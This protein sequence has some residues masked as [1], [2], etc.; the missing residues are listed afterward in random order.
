MVIVYSVILA[1]KIFYPSI[2]FV[3]ESKKI[4]YAI[5]MFTLNLV[6]ITR[7]Y[8]FIGEIL[9]TKLKKT[10]SLILYIIFSIGTGIIRPINVR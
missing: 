3:N 4:L 5:A 1:I 6:S 2:E 9:E 8:I 7:Y 10:V